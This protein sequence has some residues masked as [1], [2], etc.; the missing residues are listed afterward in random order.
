MKYLE[1]KEG[2]RPAGADIEQPEIKCACNVAGTHIHADRPRD[3]EVKHMNFMEAI[4]EVR[5]GKGIKRVAW[6]IEKNLI[7]DKEESG[8]LL[9]SDNKIL[10]HMTIESYEAE[11]WIVVEPKPKCIHLS[12]SYAPFILTSNPPQQD[13]ICRDCGYNGRD[14]GTSIFND[15]EETIQK[16]QS[17]TENKANRLFNTDVNQGR[18]PTRR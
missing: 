12:K 16:F 1:A 11:D 17:H 2:E 9:W 8:Y 4:A 15:Y 14:R 5:K 10:P 13:W 3:N 7:L 6:N 18:K